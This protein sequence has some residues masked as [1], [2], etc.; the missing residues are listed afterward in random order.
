MD[1]ADRLG[2]LGRTAW[3]ER[4]P[5]V[6]APRQPGILRLAELLS[7]LSYALD[8]TEGQPAGHCVRC[9]WIGMQ[10]G[11]EIGLAPADL[12][13]LYY[14]LLL[15]DLG[16]SNAARICEL[17]LTD[18]LEFKRDFKAMGDSLPQILRFVLG[19]TGLKAGLAERFEAILNIVHNGGRIAR[20]LVETRCQRGAAIARQMRFSEAVAIGIRDLDEHWDGGGKPRGL[21]G[22]AIS[23]VARIPSWRKS[24][25]CSTSAVAWIRLAGSSEAVA[26]P[27]SIR[28]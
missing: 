18:D 19:H 23:L 7:A 15:K 5:A 1:D 26:A 11:R 25:T 4:P 16:C 24:S 22:N 27:G 2:Q 13:T 20:E 21:Q 28:N 12:S 9:C 3:P 14:A 10:I 8:M 6:D 17:Y